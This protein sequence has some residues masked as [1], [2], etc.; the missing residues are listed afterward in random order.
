M[1]I[2]GNLRFEKG[3]GQPAPRGYRKAWYE[4]RRYVEVYFPAPLHWLFRVCRELTHRVQLVLRAPKVEEIEAL[5][6]QQA[7]RERQR[8][9]E[10]FA[11]GYLNGWREC[12]Q[13]CLDALEDE[14]S[15]DGNIWKSGTWTVGADDLFGPRN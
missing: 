14:L 15:V 8:L 10:E 9:T 11:R 2:V 5:E 3:L 12:F 6:M 1:R 4:P 13:N 7:D